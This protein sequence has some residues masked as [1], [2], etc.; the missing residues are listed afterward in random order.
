MASS[1]SPP[2]VPVAVAVLAQP[3]VIHPLALRHARPQV[4]VGAGEVTDPAVALSDDARQSVPADAVLVT[5]A[6][7]VKDE[8][9]HPTTAFVIFS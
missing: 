8:G 9:I 2:A 4:V 6:G 5:Y 7:G 3:V 1:A